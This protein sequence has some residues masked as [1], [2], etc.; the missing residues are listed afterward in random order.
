M[1]PTA[2]TQRPIDG[3]ARPRQASPAGLIVCVAFLAAACGGSSQKASA[4]GGGGSGSAHT[5]TVNITLTPQGCAPQPATVETGDIQ[6]NVTNKN[7]DAISEAELRTS[8]LSHLLGEQENLAPGLAGGFE[9]TVEP[10]TT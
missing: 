4:G 8:N 5:T 2:H 7:A 3:S 9:L 1:L 6:F 10:G